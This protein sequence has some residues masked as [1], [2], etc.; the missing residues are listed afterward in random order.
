MPWRID[1]T[2]ALRM[3]A[4]GAV[5]LQLVHCDQSD[6]PK[7]IDGIGVQTWSLIPCPNGLSQCI[8]QQPSCTTGTPKCVSGMCVYTPSSGTTCLPPDVTF[9][10]VGDANADCN[11]S[12]GHYPTDAGGCGVKECVPNAGGS[13]CSWSTCQG[14]TSH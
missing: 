4:A 10:D 11:R 9:C 14:L 1:W 5:L 6:K 2:A 7:P 3:T 13:V 12:D 8:A